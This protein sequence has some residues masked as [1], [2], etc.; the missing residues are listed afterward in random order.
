MKKLILAVLISI[1]IFSFIETLFAETCNNSTLKTINKHLPQ[2][3]PPGTKIISQKEVNGMCQTILEFRGRDIPF[4]STEDFVIVGQ[5][6]KNKKNI[7]A[8]ELESIVKDLFLEHKKQLDKL[9]V[10]NYSPSNKKTE[11]T[12]YFFTDPLCPYCHRAIK[13]IKELAK[14]TNSKIKIILYSVH[15]PQ[16]DREIEKVICSNMDLDSYI[17]TNFPIKKQIKTCD[18]AKKLIQDISKLARDLKINSVPTFFLED[19]TKIV[20]ANIS[21]IK[22]AII[23]NDKKN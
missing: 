5:M 11:H 7:P 3:L 15:T 10:F 9:S 20:G 22:R 16:G 19:G 18:R 2:P 8:E 23:L 13:E 21:R 1:M 12:I 17:T 4:Y 6:F 14:N